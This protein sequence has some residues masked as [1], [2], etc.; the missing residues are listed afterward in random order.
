MIPVL[1]SVGPV[2]LAL[3]AAVGVHWLYTALSWGWAGFGLGPRTKVVQAHT[4]LSIDTWLVQAGLDKVNP[5]EFASVVAALCAG[6]GVCAYAVFGSLAV[7]GGV[8]CFA[9][10]FSVAGY[11]ARRIDRRQKALEAWPQMIEEIRMQTSS[12]G[13]SIPQALFEVGCR[14]PDELRPAFD[15]AYR[16]WQLTTDLN[17]T[18]S[19]LKDMLA[20]PTA[21]AACETLLIAH[22]VGGSDLDRRLESLAEDRRQDVQGRK[23][24]RSRQAGARFAR[25][26]VLVVPVGMALAGMSIGNGRDAY[27]SSTGQLVVLVALILVIVCWIWAGLVMRLPE[28]ERVFDR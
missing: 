9:A 21:D 17:S 4:H 3:I 18:L 12:L 5:K 2:V 25:T 10:S 13:R 20:D 27:Q 6:A 15:A 11:R 16:E 28:P 23:E 24:A 26:F 14:S 8:A 7:A 1:K 19:V 22:E